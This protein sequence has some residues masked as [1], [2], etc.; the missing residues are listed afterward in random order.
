MLFQLNGSEKVR[1]DSSGRF[2]IGTTSSGQ[3]NTGAD[4]LV[5][6]N[7]SQGNNGISVV[8]NNANNGALFFADQDAAVRGGIRYQHGA[9]LSQFYA[10]GNIVLNLKNKGVGINETSPTEDA[11]VIRGGDTNDTLINSQTTY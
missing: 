5:V 10:G 2:L 4:D 1:I 9:D 3:S 11:L 7:T 8:T 6:G